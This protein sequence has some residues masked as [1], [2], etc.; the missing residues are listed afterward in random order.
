MV[1][2]VGVAIAAAGCVDQV[3]VAAS[4]VEPA[5]RVQVSN[6]QGGNVLSFDLDTG[7]FLGALLGADDLPVDVAAGGFQPSATA[8]VGDEILVT[9]YVS[10]ELLAFDA[11]LGSFRGVVHENGAAALR[12]EEPASLCVMGD[13]VLVLGNDTRNVG[14]LDAQGEV[15]GELGGPVPIRNPHGLDV[16]DDGLVLIATS[17]ST[18]ELGLVQVW[19]LATG[20]RVS[21]FAPWPEVQEGTHVVLDP[22]GRAV[23]TDWFQDSL[24]RY[25]PGSGERIDVWVDQGLDRPVAVSFAPDGRAF[26]LDRAG[27]HE[28]DP[29]GGLRLVVDGTDHF[30]WP[31]NLEIVPAP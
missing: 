18:V 31:R 23:V 3:T 6:L 26:V 29:F 14:I 8:V 11:H 1:G 2:L 5:L 25:D 4:D 21:H 30:D 20:E 22:A 27:V 24:F 13:L 16:T 19:D 15:L 12:I 7:A 17:P 10:G 9:N 28:I